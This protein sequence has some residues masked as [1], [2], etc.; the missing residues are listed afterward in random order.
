LTNPDSTYL[1]HAYKPI[2]VSKMTLL[3][4]GGSGLKKNEENSTC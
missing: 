3:L 2:G 1:L 4:G